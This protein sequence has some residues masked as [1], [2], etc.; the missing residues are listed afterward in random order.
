MDFDSS[1][2]TGIN[3]LLMDNSNA[4]C[5]TFERQSVLLFL[6]PKETTGFSLTLVGNE[7]FCDTSVPNVLIS[8]HATAS[9]F[10]SCER[11]DF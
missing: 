1:V 7:M 6:L 5:F 10:E 4:T 3:N 11:V 8:H 2:Y 9:Q